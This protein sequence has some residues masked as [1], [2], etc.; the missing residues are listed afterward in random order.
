VRIQRLD[1][2]RY[3]CFTDTRLELPV[4]NS[5]IHIV[6]GPNEAGKSTAL[7]AIEE[8]LFGIANNSPY[9]FL[10]DYGSM[11]IGAILQNSGK[12]LEV[13]RRKGHKDTLLT[14]DEV[15]IAGGEGALTPFL[16]GADQTFFARMF[17][18]D[19]E[20]LRNWKRRNAYTLAR[21]RAST[22]LKNSSNLSGASV[23]RWN[24]MRSF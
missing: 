17:S 2:L 15:P 18:L 9:K 14:A 5:D 22:L 21:L 3:G 8:L 13:R 1:L 23:M 20:R 19:H 10:H 12:T 11:R 4:N 6:F 7:S 16:A 24:A